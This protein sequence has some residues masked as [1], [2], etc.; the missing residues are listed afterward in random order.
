MKL[1]PTFKA[2]ILATTVLGFAATQAAA[3]QLEEITVTARKK[4]ETLQEIPLTITAFT[5]EMIQR[6]NI[7]NVQDVVKYTPG[8][9]YDKGFAA[10]DTRISIRGLPV[11]RGKPPVGVLLDG[12]DM[13]SESIS[14]AG[15]SSLVNMKLVDV[16][17]IA[18]V[19][20]PQSALYGRSAF[21]GAVVYTSV[22]PN[23]QKVEGNVS[24]EGA[25]HNFFEGRAAISVP[26]VE[27]RVAVRTN[28][29]Y[30][31]FD[32]FYK[33][34]ITGNVIGGDKLAGASVA[35]RFK[36]ADNMDFTFRSSYSDDKSEARP[37]YYVGQANGL[38]V[39]RPLPANAIGLRLG[40]PPG[41]APLP[42]TW[43][44]AR[45]GTID[46]TGNAIT[47]SADPL[48]GKD[49]PGGRLR[50]VVN[51]LIGDIDLGWG[52]FSTWTGYTSALSSGKTD[53]D[54]YGYPLAN[55]TLPTPGLAEP[56]A[57]MFLTDI[58]VKASQ[59]SQEVRL[60]SDTG[61]L[62][63]AIG[64]LYWQERYK[65]D[66]ASLSVS[67]IGK[68]AGFSAA[69]A[70]QMLGQAPYAR[71]ARNTNHTSGY[72]SLDFDVTDQIQAS[73]EARYAHEKVDSVLGPALN[74]GLLANGAPFYFF[75]ATPINPTP[76]YTTNMFTPR[77]VLK[78]KFDSNNNVYVSFSK[79]EK[80]GG[81]LNV[82]V[83]TDSKLARYNPE[84]IYNYEAGF[85]TSWMENRVRVNGSY[86]HAE[87]KDR[88]NQILI[89][90]PTSPQGVATQA[91]NIGE[92]KIDG[93]EF[94]VT[95]AVTEALTA[96]LAYT[97]LNPRYTSSD[98][99][100]TSAFGAAGAG[101]CTVGA[102]GP[103]V[104][105]IT[106]TNGN[107]LDFSAKHSLA[108]SL[109]YVTP[110]NADWN[111][112]SSID[113]QMRSRR[114]LDATNLYALPSYWNVDLKI[115]AETKSYGIMVYVNN[116][117]DDSKPKSGQ[118]AGD[119]Y[120]FTPPQLVFTAYAADKRQIGVRLNAK[121]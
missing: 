118:T 110:L 79:G 58:N 43:P 115:G 28:V 85:K 16:E 113:V 107:Q 22:K 13:S 12:I 82:A 120:S 91:V 93:I 94:E 89:P 111:L 105:C 117:F 33:N 25:T 6:Q 95:A 11:V 2:A 47:L 19:K 37:S 38:V 72:A 39:Q 60:G 9:N 36:P 46:V 69:R 49:F 17:S 92:V 83:V 8:L 50:P 26:I 99:P 87:N 90:D 63:W 109:N 101:N 53:A 24:I 100:Q 41:G 106:N 102:V 57:A 84:K 80:P 18:V 61:R 44:F 66:N 14:T 65:S 86:F 121:F 114:F 35:I 71:N 30:S 74:L 15:G 112:N 42:A 40:A 31:Y 119:T 64:G 73:A 70:Y 3:Q 116:L 29:V 10:Q 78:Y 7:K 27:D 48:T 96:S 108:G 52:K 5:A 98:A 45:I 59:F 75:G 23:L 1:Q 55:V 32:G 62:R 34:T 76:T 103:Q 81:Y 88:L 68:P 56:S 51:S 97:Y 67:P 4:T 77:A 21:G 54:F 20:G 104:V